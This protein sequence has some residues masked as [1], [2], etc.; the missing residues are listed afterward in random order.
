MKRVIVTGATSMIGV[1]LMEAALADNEVEHIYAVIHPGT[2]KAGRIPKDPRIC[3]VD[4]DLCEYE[5]L[6]E[7][8]PHTCDVFYHLAWPRT[9]TYLESF[10][11]I[12]QKA[13][14][15]RAVLTAVKA[16]KELG[17]SKFVGAGSQA[18]YGTAHSGKLAPDTPCEP[19]RADGVLKYAAGKLA[20]IQAEA[21]GMSCVWIRIFSVYGR[22]DRPN[23]MVSATIRRLHYKEHC[24][25]TP[26]QQLWDYLN[27]EDMGRAFY[28]AGK[29]ATG[30]KV[31]CVGSGEERPLREFIETIRDVVDPMAELGIGELLYPANP[32]MWLCADISDFQ[33]DTGW[34]PKIRFEKGIQILYEQMVRDRAL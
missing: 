9:A 10:E 8:I 33:R 7:L 19:V 21:Y 20:R 34:E 26:S 12:C 2:K 15:I 4:C 13:G 29:F 22:Y 18:E 31:Y 23:S 30:S 6:P 11:D 16:A 17:C 24:S 5:A 27:V 25:F 28:F 1:A 32:V 3:V 14:N